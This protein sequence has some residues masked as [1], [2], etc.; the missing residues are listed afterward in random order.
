MAEEFPEIKRS[1]LKTLEPFEGESLYAIHREDNIDKERRSRAALNK[2]LAFT[3]AEVGEEMHEASLG[4]FA[5]QDE[6][7]NWK[8][9]IAV[10]FDKLMQEAEVD[11]K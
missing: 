6:L 9:K 3:L 7:E 1:E 4:H 10:V 2:A 11:I 5:V 8:R